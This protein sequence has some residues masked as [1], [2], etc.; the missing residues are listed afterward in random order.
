[1][2]MR[3]CVCVCVCVCACAGGRIV[4]LKKQ[5]DH[6]ISQLQ[7]CKD[8]GCEKEVK[9]YWD[10]YRYSCYDE[11]K[12]DPE[13]QDTHKFCEECANEKP[14]C[15]ALYKGGTCSGVAVPGRKARKIS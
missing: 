1:M 6:K 15:S 5:S 3:V 8:I 10:G 4:W 2:Y 7:K 14:S 13:Y 11:H 9:E 12:D